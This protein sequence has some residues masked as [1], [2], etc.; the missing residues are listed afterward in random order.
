MHQHPA[1]V[2]R[3]GRAGLRVRVALR[4]PAG[5]V[6]GVVLEPVDALDHRDHR[7]IREH[8]LLELIDDLVLLRR[9]AAGY[10][11]SSASVAGLE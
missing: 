5:E 11:F 4:R 7:Q 6:T 3:D 8:D 1:E 2:R 10:S 9:V